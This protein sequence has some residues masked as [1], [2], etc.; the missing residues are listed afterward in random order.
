MVEGFIVDLETN[1]RLQMP[2]ANFV[3]EKL[4]HVSIVAECM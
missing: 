4:L 3:S 1:Q 2:L